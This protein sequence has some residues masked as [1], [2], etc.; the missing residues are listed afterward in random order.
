MKHLFLPAFAALFAVATAAVAQEEI[1]IGVYASLTGGQASYGISQNN[2]IVMGAEEINKAGGVLGKPIKLVVEDD[3]STPGESAT[4]V[5]KL[6]SSDKVCAI[7]G[8]FAS[9]RSLEGGPICQESKIPMISPGST[10]PK[11]TEIGDYIFRTCFMDSFQGTVMARFAL[12]KGYKKAAVLTDEKQDYS[13][14]L[15]F[16]FKDYFTKN[17]GQIVK[18]QS[19][20]SGDKDFR[21]QLT[22]I[23]GAKPDVIFLPGYYNEVALIGGQARR[24]GVKVPFLGGDGW[25]GDSLLK[26]A[27]NTLDGCYFSSHFSADNQDPAVQDFIKNYQ[28]KYNT[29]PDCQAAL[30]YDTVRLLAQAI[31][32]AGS[33]DAAAIRDAIAGVKDFQGVTGKIS[34]DANRNASKPAVIQMIGEGH[35]KFVEN[36]QP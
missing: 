31:T 25:E 16:Y 20:S 7:L 8:E 6:I 12:A 33:T 9:S 5:R 13:K 28:A 2:A 18:E 15:A 17:G 34:L 10:N 27:G 21:A 24:F 23:K 22:S 35:F 11:V 3:R 30:G 36:A 1:K 32:K 26:V 19:Y 29:V 14:G 4:I